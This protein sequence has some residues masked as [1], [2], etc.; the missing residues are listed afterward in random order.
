MDALRTLAESRLETD[1]IQIVQVA[2]LRGVPFFVKGF[3]KKKFPSDKHEWVLMD[4]KGVFARAYGFEPEKCNMLLFDRTDKLLFQ[5]AAKEVDG[6]VLEEVL[7]AIDTS[8]VESPGVI[9]SLGG[10]VESGGTTP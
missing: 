3:V 1:D 8:P 5:V 9:P 2:D 7:G 6:T 4:W 10:K